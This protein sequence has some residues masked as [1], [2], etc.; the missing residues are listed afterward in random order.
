MKTFMRGYA[1]YDANMRSSGG[2]IVF[3]FQKGSPVGIDLYRD[4]LARGG[5]ELL[6]GLEV[7]LLDDD[8]YLLP[9]DILKLMKSLRKSTEGP[10][11]ADPTWRLDRHAR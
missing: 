6:P 8:A 2:S 11:W 10:R 4:W 3:F 9:K 1:V 5:P 7:E